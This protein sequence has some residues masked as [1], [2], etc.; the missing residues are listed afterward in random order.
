MMVRASISERTTFR[1][2]LAEE[3]DAL[4][5]YGFDALSVWR[6]KVSDLPHGEARRLLDAAGVRVSSLQWAGGFTGSDGRTFRESLTDASE[7]I[8]EAAELGTDVL[9]IDCDEWLDVAEI[10]KV[11]DQFSQLLRRFDVPAEENKAARL[12]LCKP[13]RGFRIE[14]GSG[15]SGEKK[16]AERSAAVHAERVAAVR[17][18]FNVQLTAGRFAPNVRPPGVHPLCTT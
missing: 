5:S 10:P 13:P 7:A 2:D 8:C 1:W 3:L 15:N 14:F 4:G 6:P 9:L 11:V 12:E 18:T 17:E 16:L